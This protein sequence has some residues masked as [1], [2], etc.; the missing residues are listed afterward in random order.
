MR[1]FQ[2]FPLQEL[3]VPLDD[4]RIFL[5]DSFPELV[6]FLTNILTFLNIDALSDG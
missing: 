5:L 6:K 2:I 1:L 3:A 4:Y